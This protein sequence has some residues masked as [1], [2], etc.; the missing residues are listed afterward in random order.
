MT[1]IPLHNSSDP[2]IDPLAKEV[3]ERIT[4]VR[5]QSI[6]PNVYKALA[7]HPEALKAVATLGTTVYFQN[8]MT[9]AQRELAYL[10]TSVVNDC[11]Y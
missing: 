7:N 8:S 1:R 11:H 2:D 6:E 3:L 4:L 5:G 9:P 10:T